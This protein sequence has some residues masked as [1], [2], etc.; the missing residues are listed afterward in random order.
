MRSALRKLRSDV[1]DTL[2]GMSGHGLT[3]LLALLFGGVHS[4]LSGLLDDVLA[5]FQRFLPS[6][7]DPVLDLVGDR[8]ESL[9]LDPCGR[10]GQAG[11]EA[12]GDSTGSPTER[13]L[14]GEANR[15]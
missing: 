14:L 4:A 8:A 3:V 5:A 12:E 15:P 10:C 9:V 6:L 2:L 7:L 13:V 11:Q 1:L